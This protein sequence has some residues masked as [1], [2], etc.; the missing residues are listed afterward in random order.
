MKLFETKKVKVVILHRIS[1]MSCNLILKKPETIFVIFS[2]H[3][4]DNPSF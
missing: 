2:M 4:P 1:K 3:F